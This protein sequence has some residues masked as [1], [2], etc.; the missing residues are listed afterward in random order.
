MPLILVGVDLGSFYLRI[1]IT[2]I[3][4]NILHKFQTQTEM[5]QGRE[6]VLERTFHSIRQVNRRVYVSANRD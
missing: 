1:V 2:D 4:G 3:N 6:R 5:R